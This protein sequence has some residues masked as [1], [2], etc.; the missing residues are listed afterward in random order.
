MVTET[1]P[2]SASPM[3]GR[4]VLVTG[5]SRGLGRAMALAYAARGADV[6][7]ASRKLP[8]CEAVAEEIRASGRRAW[9]YGCHL[10]HWDECDT[11]VERT[12][13]D[14]G[15]VD[16]L[17]NNAGMSPP[18]GALTDVGEQLFDKVVAINLKAPFR[19]SALIGARMVEHGSGGSILNI[20]S[21]AAIRPSPEA[22]P[23]A[24]AKAGLEVLTVGFA[25]AYA[26]TVRV[27]SI[28]AGPFGTDMSDGWGERRISA[29]SA[30]Q[31]L[32]RLGQPDDIVGAALFLTDATASY[33]TGSVV[34]VDGGWGIAT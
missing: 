14:A 3:A 8:A 20:T 32:Q 2:R 19:L 23:Y 33:V 25:Q 30:R 12:Y 11:L 17:V 9:A 7:V 15:R 1:E 26:P 21:V 4:V 18:Y 24:A 34:R 5:G 31:P 6:V 28:M 27:N 22:L 13:A 10:A 16:V 29:M